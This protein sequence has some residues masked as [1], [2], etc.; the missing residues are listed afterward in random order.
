MTTDTHKTTC[1]ECGRIV[2]HSGPDTSRVWCSDECREA[3]LAAN[4]D[5]ATRWIAVSDWTPEQRATVA[6]ILG[7]GE[8]C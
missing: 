4:P 5:E 3:W 7:K 8:K 6:A 2:G 1:K